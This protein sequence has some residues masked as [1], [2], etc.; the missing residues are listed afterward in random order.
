MNK[1]KAWADGERGRI[2]GLSK[3]LGLPYSFTFNIAKG[4]KSIPMIHAANIENFTGGAVTRKDMF[5]DSWERIWPELATTSTANH[6]E[7]LDVTRTSAD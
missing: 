7:S 5:P 4:K 1:L 6:Q 2:S 3:A